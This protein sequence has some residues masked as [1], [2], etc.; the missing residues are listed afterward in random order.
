MQ[1]DECSSSNNNWRA[2]LG[3]RNINLAN[4]TLTPLVTTWASHLLT[5][6]TWCSVFTL[7]FNCYSI[8][9]CLVYFSISFHTYNTFDKDVLFQYFHS[10]SP[11]QIGD[12]NQYWSKVFEVAWLRLGQ[13]LLQNCLWQLPWI[14]KSKPF[15]PFL[16][17][18]PLVILRRLIF[19]GQ[20]K[21]TTFKG[22]IGG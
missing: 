12:C 20:K 14:L 7:Q 19:L 11:I 6:Q 4:D 15:L 3:C 17:L 16:L 22:Q 9:L 18:E 8:H 1:Q 10:M 2:R 5:H 21:L 13:L